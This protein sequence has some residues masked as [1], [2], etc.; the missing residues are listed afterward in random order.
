MTAYPNDPR[1]PGAATP[2][3]LTAPNSAL[4]LS[5]SKVLKA[6]AGTVVSMN[7][8]VA[9]SSPGGIFDCSSTAATAAT[10][11]QIATIPNT[12]GPVELEFPCLVGITVVP[13]TGQRVSLAYA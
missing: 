8:L 10:A 4:C 6:S 12:V 9:G 3:Y 2:A 11:N 7:V 5:A 13:G 1:W